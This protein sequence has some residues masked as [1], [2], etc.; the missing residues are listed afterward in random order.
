MYWSPNLYD[1]PAAFANVLGQNF[2]NYSQGM[3]G[4]G[5]SAADAYGMYGA[6]LASTA[7]AQANAMSAR[8]GANAMAEA[9][10]QGALSNLGTAALGAYGG[11][12]NS[13]FGAWAANQQ[14]YNNA[15]AQMHSANQGGLSQYG[16]GQSNALAQLGNAYGGLGRARLAAGALSG[17]GGGGY[18][19]GFGASG[20]DG[21]V[22]S[23]SYSGSGGGGGYGGGGSDGGAMAGLGGLA[24]GIRSSGILNALT[25]NADAGRRQIDDQHY[26]SRGM[27]SMMLDQTLGGLLTLGQ[28]AYAGIA[29]GMDQ[30]YR[31]NRFDS[32]PFQDTRRDLTRGYYDTGSRL[33]RAMGGLSGGYA[34]ANSQ[35]NDLWN[36]SLGR[37]DAFSSPAEREIMAREG[38]REAQRTRD[39]QRIDDMTRQRDELRMRAA[40]PQYTYAN[41]QNNP[42]LRAQWLQ[43][44]ID[45]Y[46]RYV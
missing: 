2:G 35:V 41:M 17:M 28:P 26:S 19:G 43:P 37:H 22:A 5:R 3:T 14:A 33:D 34:T 40:L 16:I 46:R 29:N 4:L 1:Q 20:P 27:P 23:G 11:A 30:F 39:L 44:Q 31:E 15:A 36:R 25:R 18:G 7:N 45:R 13:A 10:R 9:A 6:G 42:M 8:Y 32:R 21:R 24:S 12:A 38:A